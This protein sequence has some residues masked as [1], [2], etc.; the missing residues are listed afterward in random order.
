M[1]PGWGL[2]PATSGTVPGFS[3][4]VSIF[5]Y[6]LVPFVIM[7]L[8]VQKH[9]PVSA[10]IG[11]LI[12]KGSPVDRTYIFSSSISMMY[13]SPILIFIGLLVTNRRLKEKKIAEVN[14]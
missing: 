9:Y 8:K 10:I 6:T 14:S 5:A 4:M 11:G 7:K 3:N 1:D 13:I 12:T 2:S